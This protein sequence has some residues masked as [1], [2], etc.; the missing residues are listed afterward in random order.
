M[1]AFWDVFSEIIVDFIYRDFNKSLLGSFKLKEENICDYENIFEISRNVHFYIC[2]LR[3][4]F[5]N[6]E[7]IVD[8]QESVRLGLY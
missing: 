1:Y 7:V 2:I 6:L 8:D 3:Y 4:I 5:E